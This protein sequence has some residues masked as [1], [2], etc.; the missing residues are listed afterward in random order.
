MP[1]FKWSELQRE[2][3]DGP[4][5]PAVAPVYRG[6]RLAVARVVYAAATA[7]APHARAHEQVHSILKGAARYRVGAEE[8]LVG[9]GDAVLIRSGTE[10]ALRVL[11]DLEVVVFSEV[12]GTGPRAEV[13]TRPPT[14]YR[15]SEMASDLI[16]PGY[17]S[18]RGPTITGERLEVAFMVYPAGTRA[19]PHAHPNEQIQVPEVRLVG[20]EGEQLGIVSLK[21]GLDLASKY[22]LDLVEG[23]LG[24]R[25]G[26]LGLT[27]D[28][29]MATA[30]DAPCD[31]AWR[32]RSRRQW[33]AP[34][35]GM[36]RLIA[37]CSLSGLRVI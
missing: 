29:G 20:P 12:S 34:V 23:L 7:V 37:A 28:A 14:F 5:S 9:P 32:Q 8:R 26:D 21:N 16:T 35:A 4:H 31:P 2:T 15:W 27:Q 1:A 33:P 19:K 36:A 30:G 11:E 25:F 22:G 13:A 17:S 18:G 24:R 3:V 6:Q 10:Y